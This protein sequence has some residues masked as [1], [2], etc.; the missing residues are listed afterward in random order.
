MIHFTIGSKT[1][2]NLRWK[3][4]F[5]EK[6]TIPNITLGEQCIWSGLSLPSPLVQ[7]AI[8]IGC[9]SRLWSSIVN[10]KH[11]N[12]VWLFSAFIGSFHDRF[13]NE[14]DGSKQFVLET[15]LFRESKNS[16]YYFGRTVHMKWTFPSLTTCPK[17]NNDWVHL[18]VV[19]EHCQFWT[20]QKG[21]A[22][23]SNFRQIIADWNITGIRVL[24]RFTGFVCAEGWLSCIFI[25][26]ANSMNNP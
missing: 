20:V 6:V 22:F 5:S 26:C 11:F 24:Q 15:L 8:T 12:N 7:R 17:S 2:C 13:E 25:Q 9:I 4:C 21:M 14:A 3:P 10:S 16:K 18:T 19:I 23:L 1:K